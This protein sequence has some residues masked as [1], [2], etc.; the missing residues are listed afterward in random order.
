[1]KCNSCTSSSGGTL[2]W[3]G[4]G[5]DSLVE[6]NLAGTL[7]NEYVFF[8]GRRIARR[9]NTSNPPTFYFAD[10][11][12]STSGTMG[13]AGVIKDESDYYPFGG[14]VQISNTLPQNYKF[15]GKERDSESNLDD[16]EARYY[17]YSFGRFMTSDWAGKPTDVPYAS[18]GN[19]QSL[20][21][22]SFV[23]NNP[24]TTRDADGHD[25]EAGAPFVVTPEL[26]S[27]LGDIGKG[28]ANA[29]VDTA[30][31]ASRVMML[32]DD[33]A[34]HIPQPFSDASTT[35]KAT[36][37]IAPLLIPGD[38]SVGVERGMSEGTE[39]V[40]RA[41]SESELKATQDTGL[42]RGGRDGTHYASDAVNNDAGRAQQRLALPQKPEVK[43]TME[44]PKGKFSDPSRVQPANNMPGGGLE[45]T[46]EG[47]IPV[48][49]KKVRKYH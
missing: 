1:M 7:T 25:G 19:P 2:Y 8:N 36:E 32:G 43:A 37:I 27:S 20:N 10:H 40:E 41:M 35:V 23:N 38:E 33:S 4:A 16:F 42:L 26:I 39:V 44:V 46:A 6:S 14:E 17:S 12:Q 29:V 5:T 49:I 45:R 11:L 18:F 21:L 34:P 24:T 48:K 22:Y 3:Y 28:V 9:D 31:F 47:K 13:S 15:T 30:N